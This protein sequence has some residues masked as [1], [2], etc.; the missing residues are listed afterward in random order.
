MNQ[1][2]TWRVSPLM[3]DGVLLSVAAVWGGTFVA[4]KN[5]VAFIPPYAFLATRFIIA[6][7]FLAVLFPRRLSKVNKKTVRDGAILG[8][9][10]FGGYAFQTIGLMYTTSSHA[11]FIT[12]L[13][14]VMVPLFGWLWLQQVPHRG[15]IAGVLLATVGLG[16]LSLTDDLTIN[17][18]DILVFF[19]AMCF[20]LHIFVAAQVTH[21]HDPIL[22]TVSQL[23]FVFAA[24]LFF[25]S[26]WEPPIEDGHFQSEVWL[27]LALTA[28]PATS[29]AILAQMYL[30]K[31]TTATRTALIFATEPVF[32]VIFA[33]ILAGEV[34]TLRGA[35]GCLLVMVGIL[36]AELIGAGGENA[37]SESAVSKVAVNGNTESKK[38]LNE[39]T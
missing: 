5:A 31:F 8:T 22:L 12:G 2:K 6:A 32:A 35:I 25:S 15:V 30:Q 9:C 1:H 11:G 13:S 3:A 10:L 17:Y 26:I 19:C 39:Y 38:G 27:A 18:G 7:V 29:L 4:V 14:I 33:M 16:L 36:F 37:A 24:S 34:L 28:I 21:R 23:V 20:G